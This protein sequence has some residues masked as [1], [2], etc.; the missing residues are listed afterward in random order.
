MG[1]GHHC[2]WQRQRPRRQMACSRCGQTARGSGGI[3]PGVC[4]GRPGPRE[5]GWADVESREKKLHRILATCTHTHTCTHI[6]EELRFAL[7][8]LLLGSFPR[9]ARGLGRS[10]VHRSEPF[11]FTTKGCQRGCKRVRRAEE[12]GF[13]SL[14]CSLNDLSFS[15]WLR[16]ANSCKSSKCGVNIC[17]IC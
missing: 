17:T 8:L 7:R 16:F 1:G 10:F 4:A 3:W 14:Y 13:S 5:G 2:G 12:R 9:D 15:S 6:S 11:F